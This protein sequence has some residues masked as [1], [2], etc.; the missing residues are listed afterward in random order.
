MEYRV[1]KYIDIQPLPEGKSLILNKQNSQSYELGKRE[2]AVISLIDGNRS[3]LEISEICS[4]FTE[5]EIIG[6][7]SRLAELNIISKK[8]SPLKINPFKIKLPLFSPDKV[9]REGRVTNIFYYLFTVINS[10]CILVGAGAA[11]FTLLQGVSA[12]KTAYI[13]SLGSFEQF[14]LYDLA[15]VII[16]FILSLL[17]HEFGHMIVARKHNIKVPDM[18]VMLYLFVPCAYTNLT[19]LNYCNDKKTKLK[20]FL[21]G[22]LSDC[23]LLGIA[24]TLFH[25]FAPGA[26]AKYFLI[27]AL[28]CMMSI[29]GN[30]VVTFKFDG[31]YILRTLLGIDDLKGSS[32]K[33]I[34]THVGILISKFK[35]RDKKLDLRGKDSTDTN[36]E[37]VFSI[38]YIILSVVYIPIMIGSGIITAVVQFGGSLL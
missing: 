33:T 28:L 21:A 29:I 20:V 25:I 5:E 30:L 35:N 18:G 19:L 4:F 38:L 37:L 6:L 11:V 17:L 9:F 2:T 7:E 12:E 8:K 14:A 3:P 10:L 27:S 31:Y 34:L 16:F 32:L 13:Q 1:N 26:V 22:T 24:M 23:G 15:Y 36:P